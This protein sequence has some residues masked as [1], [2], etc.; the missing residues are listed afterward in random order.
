[1][2]VMGRLPLL[3]GQAAVSCLSELQLEQRWTCFALPVKHWL[4]MA[5]SIVD[6]SLLRVASAF[7]R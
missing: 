6:Q 2:G 7:C 5:V 4:K 1:M 3:R